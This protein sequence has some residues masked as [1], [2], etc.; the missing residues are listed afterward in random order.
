[1]KRNKVYLNL[2]RAASIVGV[3]S[4]FFGVVFGIFQF[5][6]LKN[7]NKIATTL[8]YMEKFDGAP[9]IEHR[10]AFNS[11]AWQN[12]EKIKS[13]YDTTDFEKANRIMLEELKVAGLHHKFSILVDFY[14][15]LN[16]CI[17]SQLCDR[18]LTY[19]LFRDRTTEL[20]VY[21]YPYIQER[22]ALGEINFARNFQDIALS[23]TRKGSIIYYSTHPGLD[24]P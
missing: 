13:I 7:A 11:F 5:Q 16:V 3:F 10:S 14:D 12:E 22:R 18:D 15:Q 1:M 20:Y 24:A 6:Q 9:W 8:R 4:F 19:L 23:D 2:K 17:T 21:F